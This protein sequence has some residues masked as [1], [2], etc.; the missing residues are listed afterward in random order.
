VSIPR[1]T[2]ERFSAAVEAGVSRALDEGIINFSQAAELR[3]FGREHVGLVATGNYYDFEHD[4]GCPLWQT[5]LHRPHLGGGIETERIESRL[6][7]TVFGARTGCPFTTPYDTLL[8]S[9]AGS[10]DVVEVVA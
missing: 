1:V 5:G 9:V 10:S 4:C 2:R 8:S 6:R 7:R 3:R